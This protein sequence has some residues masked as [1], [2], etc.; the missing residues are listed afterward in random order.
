M[1]QSDPESVLISADVYRRIHGPLAQLFRSLGTRK[2]DKMPE[3]LE[4][5]GLV[6]DQSPTVSPQASTADHDRVYLSDAIEL[7]LSGRARAP[8]D[9]FPAA[10]HGVD[11]RLQEIRQRASEGHLVIWGKRADAGE[12]GI[13]EPIPA[14]YWKWLELNWESFLKG[15]DSMRTEVADVG[16]RASAQFQ[17]LQV[18]RS[19]FEKIWPRV[20][21]SD[22]RNTLWLLRKTGVVIRNKLIQKHELPAWIDAYE[23]WRAGVLKNAGMISSDLYSHLE[24]LNEV[25][26]PPGNL[27]YV[28]DEHYRLVAVIS[29]ILRRLETYLEKVAT[30]LP[31]E[32]GA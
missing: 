24:T 16:R 10:V 27:S 13:W 28:D 30:S 20:S 26:A 3:T 31:H 6:R 14:D 8:G 25:G 2:L 4:V 9:Q 23:A 11:E 5:F 15:R 17:S 1:A 21:V 7:S 12:R 32:S 18:S 19:A 29:E 22:A